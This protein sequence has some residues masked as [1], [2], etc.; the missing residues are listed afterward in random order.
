MI[1]TICPYCE[2]LANWLTHTTRQYEVPKSGDISV[3][4]RC[5]ECSIFDLTSPTN[6]RL[7]TLAELAQISSKPEVRDA[8]A[9]I[10]SG[11]HS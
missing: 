8:R 2:Q 9:D 4:S 5:S 6:L 10:L 1:V 7:P 3:C 11:K